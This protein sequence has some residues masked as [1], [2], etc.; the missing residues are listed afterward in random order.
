LTE[1]VAAKETAGRVTGH[2]V[3][4]LTGETY[5]ITWWTGGGYGTVGSKVFFFGH[6]PKCFW[7]DRKKSFR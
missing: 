4:D 2:F 3:L 6:R 7:N 5:P 1:A